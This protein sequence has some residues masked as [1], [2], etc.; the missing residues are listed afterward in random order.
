MIYKDDWR[1]SS[2]SDGVLSAEVEVSAC[3][4]SR[5][6]ERERMNVCCYQGQGVS[7]TW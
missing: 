1:D 7:R 6:E 2:G 5:E 4:R 3:E